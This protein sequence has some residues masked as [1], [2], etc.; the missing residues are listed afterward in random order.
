MF[1]GFHNIHSQ[2]SVLKLEKNLGPNSHFLEMTTLLA[3]IL[4][5]LTVYML[6]IIILY[7]NII[8]RT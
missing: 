8:Y 2:N 1:Y 3:T 6:Q 7:G 4:N 5:I